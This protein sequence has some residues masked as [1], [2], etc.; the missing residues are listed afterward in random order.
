MANIDHLLFQKIYLILSTL[1]HTVHHL[2]RHHLR[3]VSICTTQ[4]IRVETGQN[5]N[6]CLATICSVGQN[7]SRLS[8]FGIVFL[9][10]KWKGTRLL[11]SKS[12]CTSCSTKEKYLKYLK[13]TLK[14]LELK[15]RAWLA[16][17][18]I[19]LTVELEIFH[20]KTHFA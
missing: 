5:L 11:S 20:R 12:E 6:K 13:N 16:T 3:V 7:V 10:Y 18:N 15:S 4:L 8:G 17:W 14:Y 9:D 2:H 1:L 19:N